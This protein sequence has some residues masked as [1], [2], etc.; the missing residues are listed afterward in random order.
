[1]TGDGSTRKVAAASSP[2]DMARYVAAIAAAA[3]PNGT[4]DGATAQSLAAIIDAAREAER[5]AWGGDATGAA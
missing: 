5:Q 1:M 3:D 2:D 4:M